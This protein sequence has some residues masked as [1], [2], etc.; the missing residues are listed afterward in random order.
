MRRTG[1][2]VISAKLNL[3]KIRT[4]GA[5]DPAIAFPEGQLAP[6]AFIARII[7]TIRRDSEYFIFI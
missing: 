7:N 3:Q 5:A 4:S 2:K 6:Q 1:M